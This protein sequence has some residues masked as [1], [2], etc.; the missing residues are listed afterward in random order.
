[1]QKE[2]HTSGEFM[3]FLGG[4]WN[5]SSEEN[6]A[7]LE[8]RKRESSQLLSEAGILLLLKGELALTLSV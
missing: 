6:I 2:T 8:E 1:M 4:V 5:S 7:M 3:V